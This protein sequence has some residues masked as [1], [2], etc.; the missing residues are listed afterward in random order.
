MATNFTINVSVY[1]EP[2]MGRERINVILSSSHNVIY[3]ARHIS[4]HSASAC[5]LHSFAM[6]VTHRVQ[7][8]TG[9]M[10]IVR[11]D[12]LSTTMSLVTL[13]I[14]CIQYVCVCVGK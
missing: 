3:C 1:S 7:L 5:L 11:P 2:C 10:A 8:R 4:A 14:V 13:W 9:A 6:Y 12:T